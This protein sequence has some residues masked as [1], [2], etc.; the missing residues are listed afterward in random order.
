MPQILVTGAFGQIG[1]EL[2]PALRD[3]HGAENVLAT[4]RRLHDGA[5]ASG[6][7]EVLD[8]LS[9]IALAELVEQPG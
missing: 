5:E 7:A 8:A 6:P 4:G 2:I 1:T 9:T 3:E